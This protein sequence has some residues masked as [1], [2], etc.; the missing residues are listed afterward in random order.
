MSDYE[1]LHYRIQVLEER[2]KM[3]GQ[4]LRE[5]EEE[6]DAKE[7]KALYTGISFLGACLLGLVSFMGTTIKTK[8]GF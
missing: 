8:L 7:R 3:L 4:K 6:I 5:L 1:L 2:E